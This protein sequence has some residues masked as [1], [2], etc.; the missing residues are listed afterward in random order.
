ME[1]RV[2]GQACNVM[3]YGIRIA[4]EIDRVGSDRCRQVV[5]ELPRVIIRGVAERQLR[6]DIAHNVLNPL[7]RALVMSEVGVG[8]AHEPSIHCGELGLSCHPRT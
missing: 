4:E 3:R 5:A 1:C 2:S 8:D 7:R 6:A